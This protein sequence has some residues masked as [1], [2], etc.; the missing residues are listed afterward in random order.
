MYNILRGLGHYHHHSVKRESGLFLL[1]RANTT[2]T[3]S[4]GIGMQ[5]LVKIS[6]FAYTASDTYKVYT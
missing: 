6:I 2:A 1:G 4:L 3:T 5:E